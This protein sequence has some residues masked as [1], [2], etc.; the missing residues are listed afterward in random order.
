MGFSQ[1]WDEQYISGAHQSN[2]PWSDVVSYVM[3]YARY[4]GNKFKV[5]EIGC[6]AGANIP[7]FQQMEV[8]YIGIDGS[9]SVIN[10]LKKKYPEYAEKLKAM[11]FTETL[12]KG[13]YDLIIDRAAMTHNSTEAIKKAINLIYNALKKEG[14]Y[15][16]IDWFSTEYSDF[17]NQGYFTT[18]KYT[19]KFDDKSRSFSDLG[20]V[21]FSDLSHLKELFH[22][23]Q[24]THIQH[25]VIEEKDSESDWVFASYNFVA[26][27]K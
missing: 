23:F 9:E 13:R 20:N 18:D 10:S 2:W 27:K 6:G 24:L 5:L 8:D 17:K 22:Y 14:K 12:P 11:D 19:K 3:R 15:I 1:E 4:S 16:G 7:L 21:H 25:K 26:S